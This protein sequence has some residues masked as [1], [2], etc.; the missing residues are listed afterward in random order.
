MVGVAVAGVGLFIFLLR[1]LQIR[2]NKSQVTVAEIDRIE[3]CFKKNSP[4]RTTWVL[5][6]Y[7]FT[8]RDKDYPGRSILPLDYFLKSRKGSEKDSA[9]LHDLR[10]DLPVFLYD[11]ITVVGSEGIEHVLLLLNQTLPVRYL[12]R[13]P[14]RNFSIEK[15]EAARERVL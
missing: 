5:C 2:I 8:V 12:V 11:G 9:I 7:H 14:A 1:W 15:E 10:V 4:L 6:S 3:P 13:D